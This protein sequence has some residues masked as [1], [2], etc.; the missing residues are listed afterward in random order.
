MKDGSGDS[1]AAVFNTG[2]R[3]SRFRRRGRRGISVEETAPYER[4]GSRRRTKL[5]ALYYMGILL[6]TAGFLICFNAAY[7]TPGARRAITPAPTEADEA[8]LGTDSEFITL[9]GQGD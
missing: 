4:A 2:Y 6:M 1:Q 3:F 9:K 5:K 7:R 8:V